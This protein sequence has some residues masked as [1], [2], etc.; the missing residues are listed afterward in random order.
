VKLYRQA[1][2]MIHEDAAR[3][4][5]GNAEPPL[6]FSEAGERVRDKPN[7]NGVLQHG[8]D[9]IGDDPAKPTSRG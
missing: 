2:Q 3:I 9:P 6:A 8:R 4:F 1:E 7:R 5:I